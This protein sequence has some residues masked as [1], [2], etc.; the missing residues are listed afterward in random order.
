[1]RVSLLSAVRVE[2]DLMS[3]ARYAVM[4]LRRA[5]SA[6]F[7]DAMDRDIVYPNLGIY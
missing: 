1:V 6:D 5:R 7:C 3:A 2:D 4:C